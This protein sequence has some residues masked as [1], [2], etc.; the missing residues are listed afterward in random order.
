MLQQ[1]HFPPKIHVL[2]A[3]ITK[4]NHSLFFVTLFYFFHLH[5]NV[6]LFRD[7]VSYESNSDLLSILIA[8]KISICPMLKCTT[9]YTLNSLSFTL[10]SAN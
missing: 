4:W 6:D 7:T 8:I 5:K 2:F 3:D 9:K 10:F 1:T